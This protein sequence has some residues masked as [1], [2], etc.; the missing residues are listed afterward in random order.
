MQ[1]SVFI[2]CL[3]Q[4][5][6]CAVWQ[7]ASAI[8]VA[9]T[10]IE[11]KAHLANIVRQLMRRTLEHSSMMSGH[12]LILILYMIT[13][14]NK[15]TQHCATINYNASLAMCPSEIHVTTAVIGKCHEH[16]CA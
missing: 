1:L 7:I 6:C 12:H 5:N 3:A 13:M 8:N 2:S 15:T 16:G 10:D 11:K 9:I 4:F 14:A